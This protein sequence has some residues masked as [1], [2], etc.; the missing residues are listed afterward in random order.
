MINVTTVQGNL[1]QTFDRRRN[2]LITLI[3]TFSLISVTGVV[4]SLTLFFTL[5][6]RSHLRTRSGVLLAHQQLLHALEIGVSNPLYIITGW[7]VWLGVPITT[8]NCTTM[9][10]FG[11]WFICAESW[12]SLFL[13]FNRFVALIFPHQYGRVT[14]NLATMVFLVSAWGIGLA[15]N[16]PGLWGIGGVFGKR[17]F[18]GRYDCGRISITSQEISNAVATLGGYLPLALQGIIYL[19]VIVGYQIEGRRQGNSLQRKRMHLFRLLFASY[20]WYLLWYL[21]VLVVAYGFPYYWYSDKIRAGW[22]IV[23]QQ[24]GYVG[25]PVFLLL[26]NRDIVSNT[27]NGIRRIFCRTTFRSVQPSSGELPAS[28]KFGL[29]RLRSR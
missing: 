5:I 17:D 25:S 4:L 22:F 3:S 7:A 8:F 23:L 6:L 1:S 9:Y 10:F 27:K 20:L 28:S 24:I 15:V 13:A 18:G 12:A 29:H 2:E 11:Q 26:M 19:A 14:S 16:L 21:P